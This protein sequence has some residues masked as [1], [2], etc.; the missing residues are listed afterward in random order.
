VPLRGPVIN[1]LLDEH[2]VIRCAIFRGNPA[3]DLIGH[4][5][6]EEEEF[7]QHQKCLYKVA[8][9]SIKSMASK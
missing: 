4:Y 8:I 5:V 9:T 2:L 6:N 7:L 1:D 3:S